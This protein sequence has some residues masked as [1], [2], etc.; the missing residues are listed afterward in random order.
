M[1][2]IT[3]PDSLPY[4][5]IL[6]VKD[7]NELKDQFCYVIADYPSDGVSLVIVRQKGDVCV[8]M[9][10]FKGN[11]L[12][13]EQKQYDVDVIMKQYVPKLIYTMRCINI[14]KAQF[15][16][17]NPAGFRMVDVRVS[18]NKFCSPGFLKDIFGKSG[19][20][21]QV[22][23]GRPLRLDEDSLKKIK[24]KKGDYKAGKF[25]I[26]SSVFKS[27]IRNDQILPMYGRI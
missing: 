15:Y 8:R 3:I 10:D 16:F 22:D 26:K 17:A 24:R 27:I 5:D 21:L 6:S 11:M 13:P 20:P 9:A 25:I 23:V 14:A 18:G 1:N 19:I 12:Q 4:P 7:V 2:K